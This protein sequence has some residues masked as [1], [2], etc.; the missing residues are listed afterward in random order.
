MSSICFLLAAG[1]SVPAGYPTAFDVS[2]KLIAYDN[3]YVYAHTSGF[4]IIKKEFYTLDADYFQKY[5]DTQWNG[6]SFDWK[7][8]TLMLEI[9]INLYRLEVDNSIR[10]YENLYDYVNDFRVYSDINTNKVLQVANQ[11]GVNKKDDPYWAYWVGKLE[12]YATDSTN[13]SNWVTAVSH[14][15]LCFDFLINDIIQNL[16]SGK[17]FSY[18]KLVDFIEEHKD[19]SLDFFTLN[20][21]LLLEEIFYNNNL[22]LNDGFETGEFYS[23]ESPNIY[24]YSGSYSGNN[25]LYKLHGSVNYWDYYYVING[26]GLDKHVVTRHNDGEYHS[27]YIHDRE[28]SQIMGENSALILS[29]TETKKRRYDG[30][31]VSQLIPLFKKSSASADLVIIIGYSFMDEII[32]NILYESV[33]ANQ[34]KKVIVVG[35]R[36]V[37]EFLSKNGFPNDRVSFF[38]DGIDRYDFADASSKLV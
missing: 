22:S 9:L 30:P 28:G 2:Q 34:E 17:S 14:S 10:N 32:N 26:Q 4:Y 33:F 37:P 11:I 13:K 3:R 31:L 29:G 6:E 20:H 12:K 36:D 23:D 16:K 1:F 18:P 7:E 19:Y 21:D 24:H 15:L 25:R 35:F 8:G 38:A 27:F 5:N